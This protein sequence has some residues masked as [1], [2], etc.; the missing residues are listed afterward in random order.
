MEQKY[1]DTKKHEEGTKKHEGFA[2]IGHGVGCP[3]SRINHKN[4]HPDYTSIVKPLFSAGSR[5]GREAL[6]FSAKPLRPLR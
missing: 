1:Y 3:K 2:G 4:L 6:A 5:K